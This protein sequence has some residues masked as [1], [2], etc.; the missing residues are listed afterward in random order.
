MAPF[1]TEPHSPR[2]PQPHHRLRDKKGILWVS[3]L[4]NSQPPE[5]QAPFSWTLRFGGSSA[6]DGSRPDDT[7]PSC[8]RP[9][10]R[11]LPGQ[12]FL[13]K[14]FHRELRG[15]GCS[16]RGHCAQ[17]SPSVGSGWVTCQVR[18]RVPPRVL[19][20]Q[21]ARF[22]F[23]A[24]NLPCFLSWFAFQRTKRSFAVDTGPLVTRRRPRFGT[25]ISVMD[26]HDT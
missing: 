11:L 15:L 19:C 26:V 24:L 9:G 16:P 8:H 12:G 2:R 5:N 13:F 22:S 17:G 6:T 18:T 25:L 4:T 21:A 7:S 3:S 23:T 1:A 10:V 14:S 20:F